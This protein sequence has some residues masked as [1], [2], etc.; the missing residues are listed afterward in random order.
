MNSPF[1]IAYDC[2]RA[3]DHY[4]EAYKSFDSTLN[5][6]CA[7]A[8][9]FL[10]RKLTQASHKP[11]FILMRSQ[12][13]FL[14]HCWIK[15]GTTHIDITATQF[16]A[17]DPVYTYI[18]SMKD[19]FVANGKGNWY[20]NHYI[21]NKFFTADDESAII[22]LLKPWPIEQTLTDK[23]FSLINNFYKG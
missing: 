1:N 9:H 12:E 4:V 7:L 23:T 11:T 17:V 5:C 14:A 20:A 10:F 2:R 3:I 8:S 13:T 22:K 18:G 6:A 16:D 15:L 21:R 19:H